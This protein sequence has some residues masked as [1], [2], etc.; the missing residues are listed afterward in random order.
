ML[1]AH[2]WRPT[3]FEYHR[4]G[5]R[6]S[7]DPQQVSVRSR[8]M[9]DAIA[10]AYEQAIRAHAG[11]VLAD[12]GCGRVPLYQCYADLVD[13]VICIDWENT[14]HPNPHVDHVADLNEALPLPDER[15]D[16]VLATD[17]LEHLSRPDQFWAEVT[18]VLRPG[19]RLILGVPFLYWL[20]EQPHDHFRYTSHRLARYCQEHGLELISLDA[21]GGPFSVVFDVI[22]KN[23]PAAFAR[24]WH[25]TARTLLRVSAIRRVDRSRSSAFPLGYCLVAGK[26]ALAIPVTPPQH[27][28]L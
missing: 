21:Y 10:V 28:G 25:A 3:K 13:E 5:L 19:G 24:V 8:L 9:V 20:H 17:V 2:A 7:R 14:A 16:T 4:G 12:L 1:E 11:G 26:P 27:P 22:G 15:V 6:A 23:V 18:R